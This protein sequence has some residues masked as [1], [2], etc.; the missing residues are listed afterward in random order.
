MMADRE[1]VSYAGGAEISFKVVNATTGVLVMSQDY[2]AVFPS[3][4]PTTLGAHVDG[5]NVSAAAMSDLTERFVRA[6]M[7]KTF[8]VSVIK[9]DG[10]NVILGQG[11][12]L[13]RQGTTYRAVL[14]G[15]DMKDPQTGQDLGRT[16]SDFGTVQVTRVDSNLS[17]GVLQNAPS[18][19]QAF[20]PGLI[21]LR[22]PVAGAGET[23][24][25]TGQ[26]AGADHKTPPARREKTR[27]G[28]TPAHASTSSSE[29]KDW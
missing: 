14:L 8:P 18:L 16:E 27:A 25:K 28:D 2:Q 26:A 19:N 15:D 6:L 29:D 11:G 5:L 10:T 13:V 20:R 7:Q 3:T 1:L 4:A 21:E 12:D 17:Y 22:D 24:G 23:G 9:L